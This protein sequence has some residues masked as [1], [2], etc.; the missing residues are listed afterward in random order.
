MQEGL[1]GKRRLLALK[2]THSP[3]YNSCYLNE[4]KVFFFQFQETKLIENHK[5]DIKSKT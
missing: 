1:Q 2:T 5:I 4:F 3:F